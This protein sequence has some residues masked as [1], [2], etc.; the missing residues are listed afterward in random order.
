M[1]PITLLLYFLVAILVLA[2]I[3]YV[4]AWLELPMLLRNIV[5][6]VAA[7]IVLLWIASR[8]GLI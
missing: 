6:L 1:D 7:L 3:W 4:M 5:L 8:A 2:I